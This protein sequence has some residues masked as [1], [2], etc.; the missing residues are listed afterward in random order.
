MTHPATAHHGALYASSVPAE[1][2]DQMLDMGSS[3]I[4][5]YN[6]AR[7]APRSQATW[8]ADSPPSINRM[9]LRI[10]ETGDGARPA[11]PGWRPIAAPRGTVLEASSRVVKSRRAEWYAPDSPG[12]ANDSKTLHSL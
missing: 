12:L 10:W 8:V 7:D 3:R 9:A 6:V 2:T 4:R 11:R 5:R 1:A